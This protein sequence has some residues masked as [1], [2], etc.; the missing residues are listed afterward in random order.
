MR[1]VTA[2]ALIAT[3]I[4]GLTLPLSGESEADVILLSNTGV[5]A[6]GS[7]LPGGATD[8]HWSIVSGPGIV[9]PVSAA[10]LNDQFLGI[11]AQSNNSSWIWVNAGGQAG[12]NEPYT[13]RLTFD[14][15]GFVAS[16]ASIS[17]SWAVD[18]IGEILLNGSAPI[19]TGTFSLPTLLS[20]NYSQFHEFTITGGFVSGINTLDF[21]VTDLGPP[22]ALNVNNLS[23]T[24][25]PEPTSLTMLSLVSLGSLVYG[26][27]RRRPSRPWN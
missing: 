16:S 3:S 2:L 11:Y 24:A 9:S 4:L 14:L 7:L 8:P 12:I 18:N 13:F 5:D 20:Q 17:G 19:G 15:T 10:V 6:G 25:V 23:G 27:R 22:G 21:V 1:G 26:F